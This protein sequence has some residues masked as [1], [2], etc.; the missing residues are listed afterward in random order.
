MLLPSQALMTTA[1]PAP[2]Q[3]VFELYFLL[4][5]KYGG[6]A[7]GCKKLHTAYVSLDSLIT[8]A[9]K[10]DQHL[11]GKLRHLLSANLTSSDVTFQATCSLENLLGEV[12][13]SEPI[14]SGSCG[15]RRGATVGPYVYIV[16]EQDISLL[17][18]LLRD[19]LLGIRVTWYPQY[20]HC[21]ISFVCSRVWISQS[22]H[23]QSSRWSPH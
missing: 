23:H 13:T 15:Q 17:V 9:I 22:N 20:P 12:P 1:T 16:A 11:C 6:N 7:A 3:T 10:L 8:L 4:P 14:H 18:V 21:I 5:K 19:T 2:A